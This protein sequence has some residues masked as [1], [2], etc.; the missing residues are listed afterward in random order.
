MSLSLANDWV[1][2]QATHPNVKG[3]QISLS[4]D[5]RTL[6]LTLP[7]PLD[8]GTN[9]YW[10]TYGADAA[11]NYFSGSDS[12][13]TGTGAIG[14]APLVTGTSPAAN[15]SGVAVN[16]Q[17]AAQFNGNLDAT[18]V[19]AGSITLSPAAAG[20][21]SLGGDNRTLTFVPVA[22]LATS[23]TYTA[24]VSGVRDTQGN[25]IADYSWSFTTAASAT[26]DT[27]HGTIH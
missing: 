8:P 14:A 24:T 10:R 18:S 4:P 2:N 6:S 7:G 15:A 1:A 11:G 13:V 27:T 19:T 16:T 22:A 17:V 20:S 23:T 25:T 5:R 21:T 9:Y 12:F 3:V 26:A